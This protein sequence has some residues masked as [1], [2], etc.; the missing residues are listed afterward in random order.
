MT[1]HRAKRLLHETCRCVR[2]RLSLGR[3]LLHESLLLILVLQHVL[4]ELLRSVC[5]LSMR[6]VEEG[7]L[8]C[9]WS[10]VRQGW[11]RLSV[12]EASMMLRHHHLLLLSPHAAHPVHAS[13][14]RVLH[15]VQTLRRVLAQHRLLPVVGARPARHVDVDFEWLVALARVVG[16]VE[17][18]LHV[19]V[20]LE[21]VGAPAASA[22]PQ[23]VSL[24]TSLLRLPCACNI[25]S[26]SSVIQ[27]LA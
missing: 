8:G 21:V 25:F 19:L 26:R 11:M 1:W 27:L 23:L 14:S 22:R 15:R 3:E 20:H 16:D 9:A 13:P 10:S 12:H 7:H 2:W 4:L 5:R 17:L 24:A 6:R 18:G